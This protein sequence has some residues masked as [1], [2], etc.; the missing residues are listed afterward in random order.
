MDM[1]ARDHGTGR[2]SDGHGEVRVTDEISVPGIE[3]AARLAGW[4]HQAGVSDASE[5]DRVE[6]IA[7][8]RSNLTYRLDLGTT[9]LVL[10]G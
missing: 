5:L 3:D 2:H 8:G 1:R 6:L 10:G 7:G 9:H 4:L